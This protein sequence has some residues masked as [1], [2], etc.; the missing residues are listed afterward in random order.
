MPHLELVDGP[1][2]LLRRPAEVV[3]ARALFGP[4]FRSVPAPADMFFRP[5]PARVRMIEVAVA[6]LH[7]V[8]DEQA[9]PAAEPGAVR[10]VVALRPFWT[11]FC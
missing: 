9:L 3:L 11:T 8:L 6:A 4:R 1:L 10:E 2:V 7:G 5:H